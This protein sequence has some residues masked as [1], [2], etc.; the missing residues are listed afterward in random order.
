VVAREGAH[1][2]GRGAKY[3][4]GRRP[5]RVVYFEAHQSR[6]AAQKREA[7][8]KGWTRKRKDAL[9]KGFSRLENRGLS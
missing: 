6:S 3:T 1:N 4:A 9:I 7:Q 8:I 5:V 2:K